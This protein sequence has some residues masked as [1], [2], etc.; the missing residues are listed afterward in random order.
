MK[1]IFAGLFVAVLLA[2][3]LVAVSGNAAQA[4]ECPYTGCVQTNTQIDAPN[5]VRRGD[6]ARICIHV[7]TDGNGQPKGQVTVT[8][9][10]GKGD[11]KYTDSKKYN[12]FKECFTTPDLKKLGNYVIKARFDSKPGSAYKDSDNRDEF[13]V[14]KKR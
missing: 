6:N 8:V 2:T 4:R 13:E 14:V 1:K 5:R 10:R 11:F 3:G 9:V 12:D 7:G